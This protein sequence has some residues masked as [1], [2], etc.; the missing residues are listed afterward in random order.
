[1]YFAK[2]HFFEIF[3]GL[4]KKLPHYLEKYFLNL[5][6][7]FQFKNQGMEIFAAQKFVPMLKERN[8]LVFIKTKFSV[9]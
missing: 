2:I 1:M 4:F 7:R 9:F 5:I 6:I 3:T 8:V